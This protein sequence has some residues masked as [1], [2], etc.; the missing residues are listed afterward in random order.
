[1]NRKTPSPSSA[2]SSRRVTPVKVEKSSAKRRLNFNN[3]A[4]RNVQGILNKYTNNNNN[5]DPFE[6][7]PNAFARARAKYGAGKHTLALRNALKTLNTD[8]FNKNKAYA[9]QLILR[10][11]M[12]AKN[13][14]YPNAAT[15]KRAKKLGI[16][17]T[18]AR[19]SIIEGNENER[20]KYSEA[21][22]LQK[23]ANR[24]NIK[25]KMNANAAAM[26]NLQKRAKALKIALTKPWSFPM[27]GP[28]KKYVYKS[29]NELRVNIRRA[30]FMEA[31]KMREKARK[32][33]ARARAE[34]TKKWKS[35]MKNFFNVRQPKVK[36]PKAK[37]PKAR[38]PKKRMTK[39]GDPSY[40]KNVR[41]LAKKLGIKTSYRVNRKE[42]QAKSSGVY[43]K[44]D[45]L[46]RRI[47]NK[48]QME[49][50]ETV[51]LN[52]VRA[53]VREK[54]NLNKPQTVN[55]NGQMRAHDEILN[56]IGNTNFTRNGQN[57][58]GW[59]KW[60]NIRAADARRNYS[61]GKEAWEL[62]RMR[63]K[64]LT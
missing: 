9:G 5:G 51:P 42:G 11:N 64:N 17:L 36:A 41:A 47:Q 25:R 2:S 53:L 30:E 49:N 7:D 3:G 13:V 38:A 10:E 45:V 28:P 4:G 23:I 57:G 12:E 50:G 55:F 34:N 1:M 26:P 46:E 31:Q 18:Y 52:K 15:R 24:E 39:K 56:M 35:A 14:K 43:Y 61:K 48:L 37:A 33:A 22:I 16:A 60:S 58:P 21:N 59:W 44:T 32:N 29:A 19:P 62:K 40:E 27:P 6:N 54:S 8:P 20:V 63:E